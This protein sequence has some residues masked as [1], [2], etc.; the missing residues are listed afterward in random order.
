MEKARENDSFD[1]ALYTLWFGLNYGSILEAFALYKTIEELGR[2]PVLMPKP[3]K[4]WTDHY[5]DKNNIAGLFIYKNCRVFSYGEGSDGL[6]RSPDTVQIAGA[7]IIWNSGLI[8]DLTEYYMLSEATD[9]QLKLA[10]GSSFGSNFDLQSAIDNDYFYLLKRF[11]G[12]L[13]V[14]DR[15]N[16][17]IIEK[18]FDF[19]ARPILDP[20]FLCDKQVFVNCAE[21]S[22]AKDN[23]K[24]G[25]F[26]FASAVGGDERK[27]ETILRGCGV[28][29]SNHGS[30]L[31][32][33]ID[34]NRYPESKAAIGLEPAKYIEVEDYLYYLINS[35]F[36]LADDIFSIYL[37]VIFEKPF[38]VLA[39][40]DDPDLYRCEEF[41]K[42]LGLIERL[43]LM[44]ED[45]N[46]KEYL[47]RKPIN[48]QRVNNVLRE[49]K[50]QSAEMLKNA[51][52][53]NE[54]KEE[55]GEEN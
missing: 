49:I 25:S 1:T 45:L 28:L 32:V 9:E 33:M 36:V 50:T 42:Q 16:A 26:I 19:K 21:Q 20:V 39:N 43:V 13:F 2:K 51:L 12:N 5:A 27:R 52:K 14:A 46:A 37:A 40:K 47:F 15:Y 18:Y 35:E 6:L 44:Q 7:D 54:A 22:K 3:K 34:I 55:S 17:D 31:R 38:V 4:L 24:V 30:S 23:E 53:A 29:L 8:G 48:Y 11:G 41:L 10:A